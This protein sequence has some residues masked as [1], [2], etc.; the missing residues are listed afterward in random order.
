MVK[1]KAFR[2]SPRFAAHRVQVESAEDLLPLIRNT[3]ELYMTGQAVDEDIVSR[4]RTLVAGWLQRKLQVQFDFPIEVTSES[5]SHH[6]KVLARFAGAE[7]PSKSWQRFYST[8]HI[9][10]KQNSASM[11]DGVQVN[12]WLNLGEQAISDFNLGFLEHAGRIMAGIDLPTTTEEELKEVMIRYQAELTR[13]QAGK[14]ETPCLLIVK[15]FAWLRSEN[16][17][18]GSFA[19]HDHLGSRGMCIIMTSSAAICS[20]CIIFWHPSFYTNP[21]H[22]KS[23]FLPVSFGPGADLSINWCPSRGPWLFS[24]PGC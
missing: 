6:G 22:S 2:S 18:E 24:L 3:R 13:N 12:V 23:Q 4:E 14:G 17:A 1:V 8:F 7:E 5:A 11:E 19:S 16:L 10:H 20:T 9:D 21:R 15:G